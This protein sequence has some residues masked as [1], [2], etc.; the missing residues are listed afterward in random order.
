[1]NTLYI[2]LKKLKLF[3]AYLTQAKAAPEARLDNCGTGLDNTPARPSSRNRISDFR[4]LWQ[5]RARKSPS[6]KGT[7]ARVIVVQGHAR[8]ATSSYQEPLQARPIG[9]AP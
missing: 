3:F 7:H 9:F 5:S 8:R 2:Q 6:S 4:R 1:M